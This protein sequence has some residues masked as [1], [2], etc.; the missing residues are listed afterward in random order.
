M[1]RVGMILGIIVVVAFVV[2]GLFQWVDTITSCESGA[3]VTT[4]N[5]FHPYAC[6]ATAP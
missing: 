4:T 6:V 2:F 5:P 1:K 3:V